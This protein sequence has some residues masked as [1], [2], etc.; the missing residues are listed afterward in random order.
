MFVQYS[1]FNGQPLPFKK[2]TKSSSS[3]IWCFL[4]KST[5]MFALSCKPLCSFLSHIILQLP[6]LVSCS[7]AVTIQYV[8]TRRTYGKVAIYTHFFRHKK[9]GELY[10]MGRCTVLSLLIK[11]AAEVNESTALT[12][13]QIQSC[14]QGMACFQHL[15]L[16]LF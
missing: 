12:Q 9:R 2:Q 1:S 7:L 10:R 5:D 8:R 11:S 6:L 13:T 14:F 15:Q 3:C 4:I 16:E